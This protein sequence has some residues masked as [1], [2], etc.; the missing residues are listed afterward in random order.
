[1]IQFKEPGPINLK[2]TLQVADKNWKSKIAKENK[3][4]LAGGMIGIY[5]LEKKEGKIRTEDRLAD[6][7]FAPMLEVSE[8]FE[9]K[10][11]N[12]NGYYVMPTTY[13]VGFSSYI[14]NSPNYKALL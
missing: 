4:Q 11:V 8:T 12:P 7:S 6:P 2:L 3:V 13:E 5:L 14:I 9:L 1:M 10:T